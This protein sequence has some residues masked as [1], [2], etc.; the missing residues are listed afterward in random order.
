MEFEIEGASEGLR[1]GCLA[2]PGHVFEQ[3]VAT[4]EQGRNQRIDDPCLA[5]D[6]AHDG[7]VQTLEALEDRVRYGI[8]QDSYEMGRQR[9][10]VNQYTEA[11]LHRSHAHSRNG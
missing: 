3:H 5:T 11:A 2:N 1:E 6:D 10:P 9:R 7:L 4:C 8:H